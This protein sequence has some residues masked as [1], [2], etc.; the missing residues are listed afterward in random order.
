MTRS[1]YGIGAFALCLLAGCQSDAQ[2]LDQEQ[3][4][5][6]GIAVKRA[7]F[8][9]ACPSATGEV[10]SREMVQPA[11]NAPRLGGVERAEYTVGVSGCDKRST[12]VVLCPQ[13]GG[14]CFA[15]DG[16]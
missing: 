6:I 11:I 4:Q 7:Q 1:L 15:A 9:M 5:A 13:N 16:R 2:R 12:L 8:D 3:S 10:L 14:G